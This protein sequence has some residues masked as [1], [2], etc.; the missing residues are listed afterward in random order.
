MHTSPESR[1]RGGHILVGIRPMI[2]P[3]DSRS[4]F[5]VVVF[6]S[7]RNHTCHVCRC[8]AWTSCRLRSSV[9][10]PRPKPSRCSIATEYPLP[11]Q[12]GKTSRQRRQSNSRIEMHSLPPLDLRQP[13][14]WDQQNQTSR[15][16]GPS[17]GSTSGRQE[18]SEIAPPLASRTVEGKSGSGDGNLHL[19]S[20]TSATLALPS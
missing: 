3:S 12:Q 15:A 9:M 11:P 20:V 14:V 8:S 16:V 13:M 17:A 2:R 4:N 18:I 7:P 6:I 1:T 5:P 19:A 10:H